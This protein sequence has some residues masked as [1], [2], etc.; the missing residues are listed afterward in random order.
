LNLPLMEVWTS[1]PQIV[2]DTPRPA[3]IRCLQKFEEVE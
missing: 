2:L 3:H 1:W